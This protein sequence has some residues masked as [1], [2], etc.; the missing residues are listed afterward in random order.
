MG[1]SRWLNLSLSNQNKLNLV[2]IISLKFQKERLEHQ[3]GKM[4]L[5]LYHEDIIYLINLRGGDL[6]LLFPVKRIREIKLQK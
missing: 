5:L 4:Y 3:L 6:L 2:K 1:P